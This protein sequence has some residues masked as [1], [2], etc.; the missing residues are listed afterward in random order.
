MEYS[1]RWN[2]GAVIFNNGY[3]GGWIF[4]GVSKLLISFYWAV[5]SFY[6]FIMG[7]QN[8]KNIPTINISY[9]LSAEC[10]FF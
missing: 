5:K 10:L 8:F 6:Q 4:E 7:K 2:K 3:R 1:K 9:M